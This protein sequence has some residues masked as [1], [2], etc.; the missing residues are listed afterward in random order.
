MVWYAFAAEW[1]DGR[2]DTIGVSNLADATAAQRHARLIIRELKEL[3]G[4]HEPGLRMIVK[5]D[6]GDVIAVIPF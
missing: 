4:Y 3:R 6:D 5:E 1:R 2:S